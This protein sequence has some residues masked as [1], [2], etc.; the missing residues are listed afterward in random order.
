MLQRSTQVGEFYRMSP[1]R[2]WN[3][4]EE[5]PATHLDIVIYDEEH[6]KHVHITILEALLAAGINQP[7]NVAAGKEHD[8]FGVK[9]LTAT[10]ERV[11]MHLQG[12]NN[13]GDANAVKKIQD[14][15]GPAALGKADS[16]QNIVAELRKGYW[17]P[18]EI[19]IA[20][21]FIEHV[22]IAPRKPSLTHPV[23]P[24]V[25]QVR[26]HDAFLVRLQLM[27]SAVMTV[28]GR[29][30]GQTNSNPNPNPNLNPNPNPDQVPRCL[31]RLICRSQ[32]TLL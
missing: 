9:D 7:Q 1:P 10:D 26:A 11:L 18:I 19:V 6:D 5:L 21:P 27:M 30:T 29:D 14:V 12:K 20:R 8:F 25:Y 31:G 16:A 17:L 4:K 28:A 24:F 2:V 3:T 13:Y 23:I 22:R 32:L 15:L